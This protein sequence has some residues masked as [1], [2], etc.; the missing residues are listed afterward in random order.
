MALY[1]ID[2]QFERGV[3]LIIDHCIYKILASYA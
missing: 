3:P 2:L 1:C